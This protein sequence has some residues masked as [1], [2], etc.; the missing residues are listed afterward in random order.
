MLCRVPAVAFNEERVREVLKEDLSRYLTVLYM[1]KGGLNLR[2][3]L[4]Q[5]LLGPNAFNRNTGE[6]GFHSLLA[7][8]LI[9]AKNPEKSQSPSAE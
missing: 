5:G 8:S 3:Y 9:R 1:D 7:L 6:R 4:A 2:N